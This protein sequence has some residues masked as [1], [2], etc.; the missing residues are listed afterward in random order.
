MAGVAVSEHSRSPLPH[1]HVD[2]SPSALLAHTPLDVNSTHAYATSSTSPLEPAHPAAPLST[3]RSEPHAAIGSTSVPRSLHG[4]AGHRPATTTT[5]SKRQPDNV[6]SRESAAGGGAGGRS[7]ALL[8]AAP[9]LRSTE[10]TD[11]SEELWISSTTA[12]NGRT[13]QLPIPRL[14][15]QP[16]QAW[17]PAAVP[18]SGYMAATAL[19]LLVPPGAPLQHKAVAHLLAAQPRLTAGAAAAAAYSSQSSLDSRGSG[20]DGMGGH[21]SGSGSGTDSQQELLLDRDTSPSN[22]QSQPTEGAADTDSAGTAPR[23]GGGGAGG[24]RAMPLAGITHDLLVAVAGGEEEVKVGSAGGSLNSTQVT[25]RAE[26]PPDDD[27]RWIALPDAAA[28]TL[29][30]QAAAAAEP[31]D[32]Q[33]L[34]LLAH[35]DGHVTGSSGGSGGSSGSGGVGAGAGADSGTIGWPGSS[36]RSGSSSTHATSSSHHS[37]EQ[38]HATAQSS[39]A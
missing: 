9:S 27:P 22:G 23:R 6:L 28:Q 25:L 34:A 33:V 8:D 19:P 2:S 18:A 5:S 35:E 4:A 15:G 37:S 10:D 21:G 39:V 17:L 32:R 14:A 31:S 29:Q 30:Q 13:I 36:S 26:L 1:P 20:G 7:G 3:P 38:L 16:A 12:P 11:S 24:G